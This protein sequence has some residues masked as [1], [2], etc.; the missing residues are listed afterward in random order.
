MP[1]S[2]MQQPRQM[3]GL[4]SFVKKAVKG[5][6]G[7]VKK[8]AGSD[9]GKLALTAGALYGLGGSGGL[10]SFFGKG[11][12]NPLKALITDSGTTGLGLSK[13]GSMLSNIGLVNPSTMALTGLGKTAAVVAP[14]V[15][16][17][18]FTAKEEENI[19]ALKKSGDQGLLKAYLE[20]YYKNL[21][22][23][24][25]DETV[26]SFVRANAAYGG[27]MGFANG[28]EEFL[29]MQQA[30]ERDP[31]MFVDTTTSA[32][33]D[34][35]EGR[36]VPRFLQDKLQTLNEARGSISPKSRIALFKQY[37]DQALQTGE[38]SEQKYREMLMPFF[39]KKGEEET[40]KI[41][42]YNRKFRAYGGRIGYDGGTDFQ[43]W[44]EGKQKFDQGQ[45]A[46]QLYREYLEDKRRQKVA[47]QKTMAANG[48]RIGFFKGAQ[49]DAR[50]GRGAMSPGTRADYTPGQGTRDDNPFTGGGGGGGN[51][52]NTGPTSTPPTPKTNIFDKIKNNPIYQTVSP[53]VNPFSIGMSQIPFKAQQAIG[54][55][56]LLNK[57]GNVIFSPA[58]AAEFDM[59]AFQKAGAKKGFFGMNDELEAMQ[60]YYDFA[61]K[62]KTMG[63]DPAAIRDSANIGSALYGIDMDLVP[64]TFL[65]TEEDFTT[66]KA[67]ISFFNLGGRAGYAFGNP[68]QNAMEAAGIE[69]LPLNQN[70]AG[71]K[72]LDLRDSG[73]FIPPVGV[74]EKAD[75]IP[76]M[77]SNNE[78]VFTADAVRGMGNGDVNKGAQ[79]M[80]DMMKKL[81]NG[82][83]V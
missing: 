77:L 14:S 81:E 44:L 42:E 1:I 72:E 16:G 24:A 78:F 38:I 11:S 69:G 74:K 45:N 18:M 3:Y 48:G 26:A 10:G 22:P 55:G 63:K 8:I 9:V 57:L 59:E 66:Q 21:N 52:N 49:A 58:G 80:Y 31:A 53:F 70:P 36:P 64:E 19:E 23:N 2:R 68:E 15:I 73:G 27:R 76:A 79:R 25:D 5:V 51:R 47:E 13:F 67:P 32:Y 75:D 12:F 60:K 46:E 29:T 4:G 34:A 37:L 83:R 7:A 20:R 35:G 82:G 54:I 39:G 65:Q 62:Q 50:A 17:G 6:T 30:A 40:Q 33:G 56:S 43:K 61:Q 41:E 71:V 28:T